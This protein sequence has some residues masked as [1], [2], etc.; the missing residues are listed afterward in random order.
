MNNIV[1]EIEIM[2]NT[3]RRKKLAAETVAKML[4]N[5][6]DPK[7]YMSWCSAN[8]TR[9]GRGRTHVGLAVKIGNHIYLGFAEGG[10]QGSSPGRAW[11]ELKPWNPTSSNI[12]KKIQTWAIKQ[13]I[14]LELAEIKLFSEALMQSN[15]ANLK[16]NE[17]DGNFV[18]K[19]EIQI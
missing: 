15:I 5:L 8:S 16:S 4:R 17:K 1:H 10:L 19:E 7:C 13:K 2:L 14:K 9:E 12:T 6:E 3:S 11:S 18:I